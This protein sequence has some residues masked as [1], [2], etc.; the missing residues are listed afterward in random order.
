MKLNFLR[1]LKLVLYIISF[2]EIFL[3]GYISKITDKN[4]QMMLIAL[5]AMLV[6]LTIYIV[7]AKRF[8]KENK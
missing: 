8:K 1:K 7:A 5:A 3:F 6:N 4:T 2:I